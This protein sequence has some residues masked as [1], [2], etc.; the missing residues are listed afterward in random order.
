M[1]S[2][3]GDA[4]NNRY[5]NFDKSMVKEV[6]VSGRRNTHAFITSFIIYVI[7]LL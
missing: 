5:I 7:Y 6:E 3:I 4:I 2:A 1:Y